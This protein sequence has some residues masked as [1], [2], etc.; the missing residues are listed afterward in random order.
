MYE[1]GKPKRKRKPQPAEQ[2]PTSTGLIIGTLVIFGAGV[3]AGSALFSGRVIPAPSPLQQ[4]ATSIALLN[5]QVALALTETAVVPF[6]PTFGPSSTPFPTPT[7]FN[8]VQGQ[9][10]QS[11]EPGCEWVVTTRADPNGLTPRV[12]ARLDQALLPAD[13]RVMVYLTG[14]ECLLE[15]ELETPD[16]YPR[17]TDF[18]LIVQVD[19]RFL[20]ANIENDNATRAQLG[21]LVRQILNVLDTDFTADKTEGG[22]TGIVTMTFINGEVV[23]TASFTQAEIAHSHYNAYDVGTAI[24]AALGELH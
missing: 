23:R 15:D 13:V 12:Q 10:E 21:F 24:I 7:S 16:F 11:G 5:W 2:R 4:T 22:E 3:L 6:V 19:D 8:A 18:H 1:S 17:H 20:N 14:N 9:G